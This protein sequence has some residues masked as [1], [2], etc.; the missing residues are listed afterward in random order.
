MYVAPTV[1]TLNNKKVDNNT[2][3]VMVRLRLGFPVKER[4][5]M[6]FTTAEL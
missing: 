6:R 4:F 5:A 1:N 2:A 3:K